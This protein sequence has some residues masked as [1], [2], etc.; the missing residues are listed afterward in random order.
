MSEVGLFVSFRFDFRGVGLVRKRSYPHLTNAFLVVQP[1]AVIRPDATA[2]S[3]TKDDLSPR[4]ELFVFDLPLQYA[5]HLFKTTFAPA[6]TFPFH[7]SLSSIPQSISP[8]QPS[9]IFP[10]IR[11]AS[12]GCLSL[13]IWLEFPTFQ[14]NTSHKFMPSI[15][16]S[17]SSIAADYFLSL[18]SASF[19]IIKRQ[20]TSNPRLHPCLSVLVRQSRGRRSQPPHLGPAATRQPVRPP[21]VAPDQSGTETTASTTAAATKTMDEMAAKFS[22]EPRV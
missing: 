6:D 12:F 10:V 13:G 2:S 9:R 19:V 14:R 22:C 21:T 17:S 4:R 7:S 20:L 11:L 5:F 3:G 8:P 16:G 1:L 18:C 15:P